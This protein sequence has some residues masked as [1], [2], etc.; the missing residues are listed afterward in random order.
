MTC[1]RVWCPKHCKHSAHVRHCA[2]DWALKGAF[3]SSHEA[4]HNLGHCRLAH[5]HTPPWSV[6]APMKFHETQVPHTPCPP[7]LPTHRDSTETPG[8]EYI[9]T[10]SLSATSLLQLLP[11]FPSLVCACQVAPIC[12]DLLCSY[13]LCSVLWTKPR[14]GLFSQDPW[15]HTGL[16]G[17]CGWEPLICCSLVVCNVP[18]HKTIPMLT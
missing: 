17:L 9:Y 7:L 15:P 8:R 16:M 4:V 2:F 14:Y 1:A 13:L 12:S 6:E 18:L 10:K 5:T 11:C 3:K